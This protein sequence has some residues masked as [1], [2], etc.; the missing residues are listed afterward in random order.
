MEPD[1][2]Q[3]LEYEYGLELTG[4]GIKKLDYYLNYNLSSTFILVASYFLSFVTPLLTLA[5]IVFSIYMLYVLIKN[6]KFGWVIAF[7]I[8]IFT[9]YFL[10][11]LLWP[12]LFTAGIALYFFLGTFFLYCF[13]LKMTTREWVSAENAKR[14]LYEMRRK[15]QLEMDLFN[16]RIQ[17]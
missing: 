17:L 7:F 9:P 3:Q 16:R 13:L 12:V 4:N 8:M 6:R 10:F 5:A 11:A 2:R 15:K 1:N 14:D